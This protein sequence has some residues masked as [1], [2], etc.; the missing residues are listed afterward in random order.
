MEEHDLVQEN[1]ILLGKVAGYPKWPCLVVDEADI[2]VPDNEKPASTD[3]HYPV[4]FFNDGQFAWLKAADLHPY[5]EEDVRALVKA[6]SR[7][8]KLLNAVR[9]ADFEIH[10]KSIDP[11]YTMKIEKRK[12]QRNNEAKE[13]QGKPGEDEDQEIDK[14]NG[15]VLGD[16]SLG[17]PLDF[18]DDTGAVGVIIGDEHIGTAIL[19]NL[20]KAGFKINLYD[21][22]NPLNWLAKN[23]FKMYNTIQSFLSVRS[24]LMSSFKVFIYLEREDH[25]KDVIVRELKYND[26]TSNLLLKKTIIN[27]SNVTPETS[28]ELNILVESTGGKYLEVAIHGRLQQAL[29]G[30]LMLLSSGEED[31]FMDCLPLMRAISSRAFYVGKIGNAAKINLVLQMMKAVHISMLSTSYSLLNQL[32]IPKEVFSNIVDKTELASE[33]ITVKSDT[34]IGMFTVFDEQ[35]KLLQEQ[36][37]LGIKMADSV[38]HPLS[39]VEHVNKLFKFCLDLKWGNFDASVVAQLHPFHF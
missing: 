38:G 31:V 10:R 8:K 19:E 24:V 25:V 26:P 4:Q 37:K 34:M 1:T 29:E 12:I 22:Y 14:E 16:G 27:A 7:N 11:C 6:H 13:G 5:T 32:D 2:Q 30:N 3:G 21:S 18:S 9:N 39:L 15:F 28:S 17:Y 20:L 36:L 35:V 33:Y 23:K